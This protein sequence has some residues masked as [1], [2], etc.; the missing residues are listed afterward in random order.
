MALEFRRRVRSDNVA[1]AFTSIGMT[2]DQNSWWAREGIY[3][4]KVTGQVTHFF[5]AITGAADVSKIL[6]F[7][8]LDTCDDLDGNILHS[9]DLRLDIITLF[10][11]ALSHN[12]YSIF[13]KPLGT[14]DNMSE[15]HII[16]KTS[17]A[18]DQ[19]NYNLPQVD[20]VAAV[21]RDGDDGGAEA[22]RD[23][24]VY[25]GV[26]LR[27]NI[28]YYS[29][30]YDPLQYPLLFPYGEP[31]WHAGIERLPPIGPGQLANPMHHCA[32][33]NIIAPTVAGSAT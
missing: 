33:E 4:L 8:F 32:G 30:F 29:G 10:V 13:F 17:P 9:K 2:F 16:I 5:N 28:N 7:F 31:A 26:G 22:Q 12:P 24:H 11:Q 20:Q 14:W 25:T 18:L 6:Q 27:R 15:A 19:R 3:A 21:W 23:I 1:F